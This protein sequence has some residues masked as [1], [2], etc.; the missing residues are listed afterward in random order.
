MTRLLSMRVCALP[1]AVIL[2]CLP[3]A[4][5]GIDAIVLEVRELTVGG[6]PVQGA[7]ARLD[8]ISASQAR[9]TLGAH[10]VT[11]PDPVGTISNIALVC[12]APVIAEPRFAC[13]TG[14]LAGR[15]GPAGSIDMQIA[16][17]MRT[18]TGVTTFKGSGFK[19]AGTTAKFDGR[20]DAQGWQLAG[21]T[22]STTVEALRKFATPWFQLPRD[23]TGDGKAAIEL[24]ASDVGKGTMLDATL[25]LDAVDLTNEASTIVTDKLAATA[26]VRA[27]LDGA[28]TGLRVDVSG[29]QG[30]VLVGPVL[31]DFGKNAMKLDV[32]GNLKGEALAIDSLQ[33]SQTGLIELTGAGN[34]SL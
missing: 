24:G 34:V 9:V 16:A 6:V 2:M 17:E 31:L 23:I 18:D 4:A 20:M 28:T 1:A 8:L 19:V 5:S 21:S 7:S 33:L 10:G 30:Q 13:D 25:K 32:Q 26:R 15:G 11:L 3:P 27:R 22:G 29:R 14:Q 12:D